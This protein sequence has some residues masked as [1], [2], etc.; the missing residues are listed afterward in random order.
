MEPDDL[1]ALV[2]N[3]VLRHVTDAEIEACAEEAARQ[4]A[5]IRRK[6]A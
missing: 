6:C 5:T 1:R 2:R 3:A 4:A